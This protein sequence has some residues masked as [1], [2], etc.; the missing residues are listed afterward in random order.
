[1]LTRA[2]RTTEVAPTTVSEMDLN[3]TVLVAL[4]LNWKA[5][6]TTAQV[7]RNERLWYAGFTNLTG[8]HKLKWC[9]KP[10]YFRFVLCFRCTFRSRPQHAGV[11]LTE[12][13]NI[14]ACVA[15]YPVG[16]GDSWC[17]RNIDLSNTFRM[18]DSRV[19]WLRSKISVCFQL[20]NCSVQEICLSTL[21]KTT[22]SFITK[23]TKK[24]LQY[25]TSIQKRI[26]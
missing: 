24:F 5:I 25:N 19:S 1:M 4:V 23:L 10:Q 6:V 11:L 3:T 22:T 7:K 12:L 9:I 2:E 18:K 8:G 15:F 14:C 21:T 16:A 17:T 20:R 13:K 26:T